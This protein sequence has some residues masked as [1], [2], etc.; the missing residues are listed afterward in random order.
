MLK[1]YEPIENPSKFNIVTFIGAMLLW[2]L[3]FSYLYGIIIAVC[4][5]IYLNVIISIGFAMLIG[6][7]VKLASK[8][9]R[10]HHKKSL[11]IWSIVFGLIGSYFSW[12]FYLLVHISTHSIFDLANDHFLLL[13]QPIYVIE[14]IVEVSETGLWS[15]FGISFDGWR[16]WFVWGLEFLIMLIVP[17][18]MLMKYEPEP[19]SFIANKWYPRFVIDKEFRSIGAVELL[20][21]DLDSSVIDTINDLELGSAFHHSNVALYYLEEEEAQYLAFSN[22]HIKRSSNVKSEDSVLCYV[23]ISKNDALAILESYELKKSAF[24][25]V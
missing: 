22:V 1:Y 14:L 7:G 24:L 4:P 8:V 15:V 25:T 9:F 16:L 19:F 6:I 12:V 2:T 3:L 20:K 10:M 13:I 11:A 17:Y 23:E 5:V 18:L 21:K